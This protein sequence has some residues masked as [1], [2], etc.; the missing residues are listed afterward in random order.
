MGQVQRAS[1]I[2][3]HQEV[4]VGVMGQLVMGQLMMWHGGEVNGSA[5]DLHTCDAS[6]IG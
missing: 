1:V 5:T 3:A 2:A 6:V 4:T